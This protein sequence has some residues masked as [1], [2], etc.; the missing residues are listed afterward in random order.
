MGG[1][2]KTES[3]EGVVVYRE[4]EKVV[5]K[6]IHARELVSAFLL[7]PEA[8]HFVTI[9]TLTRNCCNKRQKHVG[10]IKMGFVGSRAVDMFFLVLD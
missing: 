10:L 7:P 4:E 2:T 8:C 5:I 9:N 1:T 6:Q 3:G